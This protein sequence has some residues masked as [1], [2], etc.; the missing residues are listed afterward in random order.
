MYHY[1]KAIKVVVKI[2][3]I[4]KQSKLTLLMVVKS[5]VEMFESIEIEG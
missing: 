2:V 1:W 4:K 3:D 5:V